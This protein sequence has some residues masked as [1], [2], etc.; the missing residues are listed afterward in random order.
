MAKTA[1]RERRINVVRQNIQSM[2][3]QD[4][5]DDDIAMMISVAKQR[6]PGL[7]AS[8]V[9]DPNQVRFVRAFKQFQ[10]PAPQAKSAAELGAN[11]ATLGMMVAPIP[12]SRAAALAMRAPAIGAG[13]VMPLLRETGRVAAGAGIGSAV[14]ETFGPREAGEGIGGGVARTATRTAEAAL[15]NA[16]FRG[17][18]EVYGFIRGAPPTALQRQ[19]QEFAQRTKFEGRKLPARAETFAQST[20]AGRLGR[21][22][23]H[24]KTG[25][26]FAQQQGQKVTRFINQQLENFG[27]RKLFVSA[28]NA[29]QELTPVLRDAELRTIRKG[30]KTET[31][32]LLLDALFSPKHIN[33]LN[34]VKKANPAAFEQAKVSWLHNALESRKA[35]VSG[36]T[37]PL[38]EGNAI[39][40]WFE[41]ERALIQKVFGPEQ[42]TVLDNFTAYLAFASPTAKRAFTDASRL[43]DLIPEAVGVGAVGGMFGPG[44]GLTLLGGVEGA[45]AALSVL[46]SRPGNSVYRLFS[47]AA[48][49]RGL[50]LTAGA[51]RGLRLGAQ[52]AAFRGIQPIPE[53]EDRGGDPRFPAKPPPLPQR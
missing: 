44:A 12:G 32:E 43:K 15:F 2:I 8:D 6:I 35:S 17:L 20:I 19:G 38:F 24:T 11:L 13:R 31:P 18:G 29:V 21:A 23:Q 28:S 1:D 4:A 26:I 25:Q 47:E 30:I 49:L 41:G 48:P 53:A 51:Q 5:T 9:V 39:R 14:G 10:Q 46:L 50:G 40:T 45:S 3:A 34:R 33:I 22:I 42:T 16:A 37:F 7:K 36:E 52:A 27:G